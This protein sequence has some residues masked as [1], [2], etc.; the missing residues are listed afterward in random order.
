[1]VIMV[2][3]NLSVLLYLLVKRLHLLWETVLKFVWKL[4]GTERN[5]SS[6][7]NDETWNQPAQV[8]RVIWRNPFSLIT[9]PWTF[10]TIHERF[11]P[12]EIVL[13]SRV[14]LLSI[15]SKKA[16][17]TQVDCDIPNVRSHPFTWLVQTKQTTHLIVLPIQV[18]YDLVKNI[19]VNDRKVVWMFHTA[20]CGSTAWAQVFNQLPGWTVF[21]EP[22]VMFYSVLYGD[23]GYCSAESFS[24]SV[25]Y[26]KMLEATVKMY[27]RQTPE[28]SSVFWK[29]K[30][31]D[32]HSIKIIAKY[33]PH[34]K[35]FFA[36]RDARP[37]ISSFDR[38]FGNTALAQEYVKTLM[39][40]P[41][42]D[43]WWFQPSNSRAF[44]NGYDHQFCKKVI[45]KV[46]PRRLVEW[47]CFWWAAKITT[48]LQSLDDGIVV[49]P[50]KYENLVSD[51]RGTVTKVF[52]YLDIPGD[53]VDIACETLNYDSQAGVTNVSWKSRAREDPGIWTRDSESVE[54]CNMILREFH[55]PEIQS[56]FQFSDTF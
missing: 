12:A 3:P 14:H 11:A 13:D 39:H 27:L 28:K 42:D 56:H 16:T 46:R 36:Y 19:D 45:A 49:K 9:H 10:F 4:N 37:S 29:G 55:L 51:R 43:D 6:S 7:M 50:I 22:Q 15:T 33:F 38:V 34:H 40:D 21:S 48:V 18:F 23:H 25:T 30:H 5:I 8:L 31:M 44:T 47:G 52:D 1:M 41:F 35:I 32:E 54:R 20:R 26:R 24:K 2:L 17:F 53:L